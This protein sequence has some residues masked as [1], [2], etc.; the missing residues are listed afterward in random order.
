MRYAKLLC[1]LLLD[2][3]DDEQ[4]AIA[5]VNVPE[6]PLNKDECFIKDYSENEGVLNTL[7]FAGI[8]KET[9]VKIKQGFVELTVCKILKGME[10]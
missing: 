1:R 10:D 2:A 9:D 7:I 4:I 5:S 6:Y 3:L 8:I